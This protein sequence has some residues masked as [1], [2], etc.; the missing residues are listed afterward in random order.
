MKFARLLLPLLLLSAGCERQDV[1]TYRVPKT[2]P[3]GKPAG[4]MPPGHP[5]LDAGPPLTWKLPAGWQEGPPGDFRVASFKVTGPAGERADISIVPLPGDAGGDLGNVNRWRSQVNL[6]P[7]TADELSQLSEPITVAGQPALLF[8]Q[9]DDANRI[10]AVIHRR[11]GLVWFYKMTGDNQFVTAQKP[12]FLEFLRSI[13]FA[14]A[15][16]HDHAHAPA[17]GKPQWTVP[18]GWQ[19]VPGGQFLYAKF[20]LP[21]GQ[22]TVNVSTSTGDGGGLAA[23]VNRW[24]GQLGLPELSSVE[25]MKWVKPAMTTSGQGALVEL[26]GPSGQSLVAVIV[27]LPGQSWFY[28][29][30]GATDTVTA[31]RDT[32]IRFVEAVR[33]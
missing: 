24:R 21:G 6:E 20:N 27:Q 3:P 18:N 26:T 2:T 19:E 8:D 7:V 31:Q 17:P 29:L 13:Q 28:K 33:Y 16:A 30:M 32:F 5:P 4:A 15:P 10:V 23:N 14:D 1:E 12:A 25:L 11:E 22:A 9:G